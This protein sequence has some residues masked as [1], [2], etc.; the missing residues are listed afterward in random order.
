MGTL[1]D[2]QKEACAVINMR[3][4]V[5]LLAEREHIPYEEAML[6]FGAST[7][8][9][10]LFDFDTGVWKESPVYLLDLYRTYCT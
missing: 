2:K 9:D 10:A 5:A 7:I 6:R 4:A 3:D 1:T 8:Y